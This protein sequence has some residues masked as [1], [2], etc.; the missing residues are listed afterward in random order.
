MDAGGNVALRTKR[1]RRSAAQMMAVR[2]SKASKSRTTQREA[3]QSEIPD[4]QPAADSSLSVNLQMRWQERFNALPRCAQRLVLAEHARCQGI[5]GYIRAPKSET[6]GSDTWQVFLEQSDPHAPAMIQLVCDQG[7]M[8]SVEQNQKK[9]AVIRELSDTQAKIRQHNGQVQHYQLLGLETLK[10][11][12]IAEHRLAA[13]R[14]EE[15]SEELEAEL[16]ELSKIPGPSQKVYL[17][18][19]DLGEVV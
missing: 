10:A 2:A 11:E 6:F 9:N 3:K 18:P 7:L 19:V 12:Q 14:C 1:K 16:Q 15:K 4:V 17:F 5:A 8:G 13:R